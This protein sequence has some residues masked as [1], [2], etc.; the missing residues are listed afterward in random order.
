MGDEIKVFKIATGEEVIARVTSEGLDH[1]VLSKPRVV[2]I[3]PGPGGQ[4]S[5]TLIPLFASNQDG[6][7]KLLKNGV[8]AEPDSINKELENGYIQQT[9]GIALA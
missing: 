8:V 7:A 3:A 4:M 1:Y 5:V 2:A 9:T 6:D